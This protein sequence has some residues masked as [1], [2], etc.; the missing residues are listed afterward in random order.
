MDATESQLPN[1]A[2]CDTCGANVPAAELKPFPAFVRYS[3]GA[4]CQ[5]CREEV[6]RELLAWTPGGVV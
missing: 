3:E 1:T 4:M 5:R 6:Y 2:S